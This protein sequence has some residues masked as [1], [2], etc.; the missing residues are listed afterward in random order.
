MQSKHK[1]VVFAKSRQGVRSIL[2][3][4]EGDALLQDYFR[5]LR[6][7]GKGSGGR[8]MSVREQVNR[9]GKN[10]LVVSVFCFS[11][12]HAPALSFTP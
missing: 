8:F 9:F 5:P 11:A 3:A 7:V 12:Q 4:V 6:L 10:N 1:V 2:D